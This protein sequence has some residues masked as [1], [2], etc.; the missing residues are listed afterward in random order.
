[1]YVPF[2][3][4]SR[5]RLADEKPSTCAQ[6]ADGKHLNPGDVIVSLPL[7]YV[8]AVTDGVTAD[9]P[10]DMRLALELL[11]AIRG[12]QRAEATPAERFWRVRFVAFL[13]L[14]EWRLFPCTTCAVLA[15]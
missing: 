14:S 13:F 10:A 5:P 2:C 4:T 3:I 9:G 12:E 8:L 11:K 7:A 6:V 1:M 15:C